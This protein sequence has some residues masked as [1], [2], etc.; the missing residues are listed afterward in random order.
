MRRKEELDSPH[1]NLDDQPPSDA[2]RLRAA[3][4]RQAEVEHSDR[5]LTGAPSA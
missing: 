3:V 5:Q 4:Q 2:D 1:P